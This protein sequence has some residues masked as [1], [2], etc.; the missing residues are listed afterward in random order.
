MTKEEFAK[1]K[2]DVSHVCGTSSFA[3]PDDC[4]ANHLLHRPSMPGANA[5]YNCI[6]DG[7]KTDARK[8]ALAPAYNCDV[9][10]PVLHQHVSGS[11]LDHLF[12]RSWDWTTKDG[13]VSPIQN[14][15]SCGSCWACFRSGGPRVIPGPSST[16]RSKSSRSRCVLSTGCLSG[17]RS[18]SF[19]RRAC[20]RSWIARLRAPWQEATI[21]CDGGAGRL[22]LGCCTSTSLPGRVS[23][24]RRP[25]PTRP[26][27]AVPMFTE[28]STQPDLSV[29]CCRMASAPQGRGARP[30]LELTRA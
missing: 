14:Q 23:T 20:R 21:E 3:G 11:A 26:R 22:A 24:R 2:L 25:S 18:A 28:Q 16:P 27:C 29:H 10:G 17:C 5:T 9:S 15:A 1:T 8:T 12:C 19:P 13:I 4:H 7:F 6:A 30:H